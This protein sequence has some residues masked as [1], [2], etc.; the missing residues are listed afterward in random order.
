MKFQ[1]IIIYCSLL[2]LIVSCADDQCNLETDTLLKTEFVVKDQNLLDIKYLDSLSVYSPEWPDS[3]HYWKEKDGVNLLYSL[4]PATDMSE[5]I[6]TSK[7]ASLNDTLFIYYQREMYML[8]PECGF[9]V[10]YTIDSVL[11]TS[12]YIDSLFIITTAI[13]TLKNGH[14]Q[15]YF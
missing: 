7:N 12:N 3:I 9:V 13:T 8:S 10:N 6:I 11:S 15:I 5:I 2:F 1:R 4:S 14:I